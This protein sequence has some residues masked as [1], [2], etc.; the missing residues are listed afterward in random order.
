M[1]EVRSGILKTLV[2][3]WGTP[4]HSLGGMGWWGVQDDFGLF[5]DYNYDEEQLDNPDHDMG[6]PGAQQGQQQQ[7]QQQQQQQQ[8]PQH[9]QQHQQAQV[10]PL[11]LH[12]P[13]LQA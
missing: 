3:C 9:P 7:E 12:R 4:A 5:D 2:M 1:E 10:R 8:Q 11:P 6:I 13:S